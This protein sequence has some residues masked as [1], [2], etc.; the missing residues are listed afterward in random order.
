MYLLI[1]LMEA[2]LNDIFVFLSFFSFSKL[3][4]TLISFLLFPP[5]FQPQDTSLF[6][7]QTDQS[8]ICDLVS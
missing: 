3:A 1:Q 8:M 4:G 6:T 2:N 7:M 5:Q